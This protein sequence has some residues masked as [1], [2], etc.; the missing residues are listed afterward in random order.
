MTT[1]FLV[2]TLGPVEAV[3]ISQNTVFDIKTW[4]DLKGHSLTIVKGAKFI[5]TGT[6]NLPKETVSVFS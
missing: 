2:V 1:F 6:Q 3:A 5:E 4:D